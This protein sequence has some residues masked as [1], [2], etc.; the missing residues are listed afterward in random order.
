MNERIILSVNGVKRQD[1]LLN[2]MIFPPAKIVEYLSSLMTLEEGDLIYTGTPA[3]VGKV[4]PG[5]IGRA[6]V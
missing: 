4:I 5:E 6:H 3:G 2:K 1:D